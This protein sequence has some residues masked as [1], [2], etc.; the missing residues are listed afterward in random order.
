MSDYP[1]K[2]A[3]TPQ[4]ADIS[5][6]YEKANGNKGFSV[7]IYGDATAAKVNFLAAAASDTFRPVTAVRADGF[8]TGNSGV[9]GEVWMVDATGWR[10][11]R[12]QLES[13]SGGS[14]TVGITW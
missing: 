9:M 5:L 14:V 4:T 2:N 3:T 13:V 12:V 8:S 7:E 6:E 11:F 1:I 10:Q